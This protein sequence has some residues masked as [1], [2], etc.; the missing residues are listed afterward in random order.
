MSGRRRLPSG[1]ADGKDVGRRPA[2]SAAEL[3]AECGDDVDLH[4]IMRQRGA[5]HHFQR[6]DRKAVDEFVEALLLLLPGEER[7]FA[8]PLQFRLGHLSTLATV[9]QIQS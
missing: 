8:H 2:R 5:G 1:R 7:L 6:Q 3:V 4:A 9:T